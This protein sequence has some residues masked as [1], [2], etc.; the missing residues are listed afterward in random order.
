MLFENHWVIAL[1]KVFGPIRKNLIV[2]VS[3]DHS[4]A[5]KTELLVL[6]VGV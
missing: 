4:V 2:T 3:L 6:V 1:F 5:R